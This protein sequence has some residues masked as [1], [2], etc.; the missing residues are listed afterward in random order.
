MV[1]FIS[2]LL[3]T[4][5]IVLAIPAAVFLA[6]VAAAAAQPQRD[7]LALPKT[8][9]RARVAALVPAHNESIGLLPTLSDIKTQM[10]ESDRVL[11]IADNCT[12]DTAVVAVTAGVEVIDRN[13]LG[14]KGK[15]FALAAGLHHLK[16]DPPDVVIMI[17]ADCRL[18]EGV[19]DRLALAC[20]EMGRPVQAQYLMI[21]PIDSL[22]NTRVAEFAWRVKNMVRPLGLRALGL[23]CQLTGTGMAFPWDII[24]AAD[25]ANGSIVEDLKLGLDLALAGSPPVFFPSAS[26]SS[27]FPVSILGIETQRQRWEGGHIGLIFTA[28]PRLIFAALARA[29]L[30]LL[31][32][33]LDVAVPPLSL[34]GLLTTTMLIVTG[35][36][37]F[38]GVSSMAMLVSTFSLAAF[39]GGVFISWFMY[40]RDILP[41]RAFLS[42]VPYSFGKVPLYF[43]MLSGKSSR[44]WIRT[45]RRKL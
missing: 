21:A 44:Q 30:S 28:V 31:S 7:S 15:G 37:T 27:D 3:T 35:F 20:T 24:S 6:E 25:L 43:R 33:A 36:A 38:L 29:N 26:V 9:P 16:A 23:P 17:D 11:V 22:T 1:T 18:A 5:A 2:I 40:G 10:L 42:L 19:I 14:R 45:D 12:D 4:L 32:L 13:D 41:P 39:A 34:L 8:E